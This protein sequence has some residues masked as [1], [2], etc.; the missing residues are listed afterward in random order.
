M[1]IPLRKFDNNINL[2]ICIHNHSVAKHKELSEYFR[3]YTYFQCFR[4]TYM[5]NQL[6]IVFAETIDDGL[7]K[8]GD[9]YDHIL[10]V[11]AGVRLYDSDIINDV[12]QEI[13]SKPDYLAMAHMLDWTWQD[14]WWELHEQFVL[15]NAKTWRDIKR[16]YFGGWK[17]GEKDL[18]IIE[19]SKENYHDNYV[20]LWAKDSGE[21]KVQKYECP[22]SN[23]LNEGY[24]NGCNFYTWP[25]TIRNKHTYYYPE[26]N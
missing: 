19:R 23:F 24:K 10:F 4:T 25:K 7:L 1:N 2:C 12:V 15:I 6:D 17:N 11:A 9:N 14:R 8:H 16:P 13:R 20:P 21:R 3:G 5:T 22:G 26:T 18:P